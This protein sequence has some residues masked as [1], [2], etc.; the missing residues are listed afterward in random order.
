MMKYLR[1]IRAYTGAM[2]DY[3]LAMAVLFAVSFAWLYY[4][5]GVL[6]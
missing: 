4:L 2:W 1:D 6:A 5:M 3:W